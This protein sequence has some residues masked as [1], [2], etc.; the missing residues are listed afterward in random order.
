MNGPP[1]VRKKKFPQKFEK[2]F[3]RK[4]LA[5]PSSDLPPPPFFDIPPSSEKM[6]F[7]PLSVYLTNVL[8]PPL[9]KGGVPTMP[10]LVFRKLKTASNL[11]LLARHA[12]NRNEWQ[13]LATTILN[14]A[15][16]YL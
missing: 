13:E 6:C 1:H 16:D 9:N 10:T 7:P 12:T 8:P 14:C 5:P 2:Y 15:Q 3:C 4:L 11:Q